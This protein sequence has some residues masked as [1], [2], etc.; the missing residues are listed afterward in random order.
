MSQ[1]LRT[2]DLVKQRTAMEKR[3]FLAGEWSGEASVL[4]GPG[5]C[6]GLVQTRSNDGHYA[7]S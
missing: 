7:V 6:V 4:R 3:T 2:P 5:Q 1:I